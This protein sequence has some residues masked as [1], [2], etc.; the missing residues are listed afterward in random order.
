MIKAYPSSDGMYFLR[1]DKNSETYNKKE[2]I[3]DCGGRWDSIK[4]LWFVNEDAIKK[5]GAVKMV[6]VIRDAFC[7]ENKEEAFVTEAE[8]EKGETSGWLFCGRCDSRYYHPV[9]VYPITEGE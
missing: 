9:K 1:P 8:R 2:V 6:K 7:H 4:Q 3:K 5:I